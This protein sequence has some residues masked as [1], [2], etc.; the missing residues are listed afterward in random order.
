MGNVSIGFSVP[1]WLAI[2]IILAAFG[3]AIWSYRTTLPP[4]SAMRRR[5]LVLLRTLGIT[6]LL[7]AFFETIF[8]SLAVTAED[9]QIVI[10]LDNSESMT[11]GGIDTTRIVEGKTIFQRLLESDLGET[12]LPLLFSDSA[13]SVLP[14]ALDS[15]ARA[16]GSETNLALP[17]ALTAD[18]VRRHNI[19]AIV[20]MTDGR[21][22]AG[23]N[24]TYDAERLGLP[25]YVVG[26]GDS[27]EPKDLAIGQLFTNEI[28]YIGTEQPIQVRVRSSGFT[29]SRAQLV[30]RDDN[31]VVAREEVFLLPGTNEYTANFTWTPRQEGVA[32]LTASIEGPGGELT[33]KNNQRI[34]LVQVRSNK[35][36]YLMISGSPNPDFAFLKRHLSQDKEIEVVTYVQRD[37][38][39]F[40][41][42]SLTASSFKDA[43]TVVLVD[44]PTKESATKI[45]D[46]IGETVRNRNLPLMTI[47]GGNV[48]YDKLRRLENLLP[49]RIGAA[50]SNEAQVFT[51]IS[52]AGQEN[53]ITRLSD[54]TAWSNMPPIFRS[55]TQFTPRPEA[56]L[57]ATAR[58]G[59]TSLNEPLIVSSKIGKTRSLLVAGYGIWRWELIGESKAE[60]TGREGGRVLE[61]FVG[62]SLR[63]LAV[64]DENQQVRIRP[65][66][67]VYNLGETVRLLAQVYDESYQPLDNAEVN[68][69]IEGG[70]KN[71]EM[72][73][74]PAGN[75]RYEGTLSNLPAGDYRFNGTASAGG[76]TIGSDAGRFI[77]DEVGLEFTQT[78][79]N[80]PLLR[81]L[82]ERTGG[83]FYT[84]DQAGS[85]IDDIKANEGF[86]P[87]SIE[88]EKEFSLRESI[89]FLIAALAFFAVEW[90]I[91]KRSGML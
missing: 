59:S 86:R 89:W 32:R 36:R 77:V 63:W 58:I 34:G 62:N 48:D 29:E 28:A 8:S 85:L 71:Y 47:L 35:R 66:K 6:L 27:V 72:T 30:L 69:K 42:G 21:Y 16:A 44:Y 61:N 51:A 54:S 15:L 70:G 4:V 50:R 24:P 1:V 14:A 78:S 20:L 31:G 18:S 45:V 82:A 76:R 43:E 19:R 88:S 65:S 17:F 3:F 13:R 23:I 68:V 39:S 37:G 87:K 40:L 7:L 41:E 67:E 90:F 33:L 38:D 12:S 55:E 52:P 81:S 75:G 25:V 60:V 64:R 2:I 46:M 57:L 73:L 56:E 26:L 79:M 83:K 53:P 80:A 9:P 10:A 49:V 22:N 5:L 84:A 74:A 91:R 11:L